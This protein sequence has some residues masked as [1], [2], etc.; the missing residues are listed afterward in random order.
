MRFSV[1]ATIGAANLAMAQYSN[2]TG[3]IFPE[4]VGDFKPYGCVTSAA[5]FPGFEKAASTDDMS[6]DMCAASCPGKFM[7]VNG[8]DCI[9]GEDIEAAMVM[10]VDR[11]ICNSPCPGNK[12]QSCGSAPA[13]QRRQAVPAGSAVSMYERNG[14]DASAATGGETVTSTVTSTEVATV[15]SCAPSVTDCPVGSQTTKVWTQPTTVCKKPEGWNEWHKKKIVCYG[16]HCA[17][18]VPCETGDQKH[19]VICEG[20]KCRTEVTTTEEWNKLIICEG[21]NCKYAECKGVECNQKKIVCFNG[22]CTYSKCIGDECRKNVVCKGDKCQYEKCNGADCN[23]KV[24]CDVNG[25]N[26]NTAP[27]PPGPPAP[28]VC[29]GDN[30]KVVTPPCNGDNCKVVTPPCNGDNCKVVTPPCNGNDCKVVTPPCYG[31][32]CKV[33]GGTGVMPNPK[34]MR[35]GPPV[36]GGAGSIA[37]NIIGAAAGLLFVL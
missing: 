22:K 10:Q 12:A 17:H 33:P 24:I 21:N 18:E 11:M 6:L 16:D 15:T 32:D 29:Y 23:K 14:D 20:K 3:G 30:C 36:V 35:T 34:P 7:G 37:V 25:Q 1:I 13:M 5:G 9:C 2:S 28:P 31:D 27:P 8:K 26:C 19:R 4:M